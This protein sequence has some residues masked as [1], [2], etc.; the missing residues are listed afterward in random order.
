MTLVWVTLISLYAF[1]IIYIA[2]WFLL[3]VFKK[4]S[5]QTSCGFVLSDP[6][7]TLILSD[8]NT[9]PNT[10]MKSKFILY[11]LIITISR[12]TTGAQSVFE[13]RVFALTGSE[14]QPHRNLIR[15]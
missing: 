1:Q 11:S 4:F 5:D 9:V 14:H 7:Q 15:T 8:I 6:C 3:A 2:E 12:K 10:A 13:R